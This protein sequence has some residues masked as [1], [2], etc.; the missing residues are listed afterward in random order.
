MQNLAE[1]IKTLMCSVLQQHYQLT[2]Q[3]AELIVNA[4][5]P[6]FEGEYSLVCFALSKQ[7]KKSPAQVA[8]ELGAYVVHTYPDTFAQYQVIQGFLNLSLQPSILIN[9]LND[10]INSNLSNTPTGFKQL[11]EYSSP[12]TNKPLHFGHLR[13]IFLGDSMC[14]LLACYGD[15]VIKA[16]LIN[17]RGI[18]I[19]KSMYAWQQLANGAT[20]QSTDSKGDHFVGDYYVAFDKLLKEQTAA[21]LIQLELNNTEAIL[22]QH[23]EQL[24]L[25]RTTKAQSTDADKAKAIN[26]KIIELVKLS[27]PC[28]QGANDLLIKWEQGD[29]TT[30][31]LWQQ[32]NSWVYT[33]FDATY[34]AMG[35]SFDK[36]YYE[37]NT[38][39]LGKQI[40]LEGV[41][42]GV[43][44][45]KEDKSI[46][47][48]LSKDGL[49][50]KL[51]LRGNG[52]SVYITQDIGTA[53]LKYK[54]FTPNKSVYV[55]A[56]E[57]NYHMQVLQLIMQKLGEPCADGIYHLSYGMVELP[58][59]RMK[60]REGT[61]VDADDMINEMK[62]IAKNKTTELGK[63]DGFTE[64]ELQQL[65]HQLG[66]GALKFYLLRVDPKKKMIFNPEE[67]IDFQGF[68]GPFVQYTHARI[69]S[70][71]RKANYTPVSNYNYAE[72]LLPLEHKLLFNLL[73]FDAARQQAYTEYNPSVICNYVFAVAKAFSSFVAEHKVLNAEREEKQLLRLALCF[74]A[75]KIIAHCMGL[76]GIEVPERM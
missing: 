47:V 46:W 29:A 15:T 12:N 37:S 2:I 44:T 72:A 74:G 60:S 73:Q 4:T 54:D 40:V 66:M 41:A 28:M 30:I 45:Q 76:L 67:S 27:T 7:L 16:N 63:V 31:Q 9:G 5:K 25:L 38:Y 13:N 56:D 18:H 53:Q 52:T 49:D 33:G 42:K 69:S 1:H 39:L 11:V 34:K 22:P 21:I 43:L 20:P 65:Y 61:V 36:V 10:I 62:T 50:E 51:L 55:I 35:I 70:I 19:C 68:T 8:E 3:P 23:L 75:K 32:M 58:H 57:Q 24:Q 6:E 64:G 17:D 14:K 71:L 59:G 48:D 26:D